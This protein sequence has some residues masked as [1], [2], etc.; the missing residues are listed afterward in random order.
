MRSDSATA[1]PR[2]AQKA[3]REA[4]IRD[5]LEQVNAFLIEVASCGRHFFRH[6]WRVARLER[7]D[8]RI[9]FLDDYTQARVI[10][11]SGPRRWKGFSHGGTMRG[12]I[13]CLKDYVL[14][15]RSLG[16]V[17]GPAPA[18]CSEGDPWGYGDDMVRVR[19]K[20]ASL[21]L[22]EDVAREKA[23]VEAKTDSDTTSS[24]GVGDGCGTGERSGGGEDA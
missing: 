10:I 2:E 17:L 18:W 1:S 21:G 22:I 12:L 11:K 4:Q 15:G 6:L 24:E 3:R 14:T 20:A 9:Y 7:T 19:A 16:G 8:G 13:L 23:G 5:R